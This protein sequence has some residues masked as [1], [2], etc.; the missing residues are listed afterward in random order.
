MRKVQGIVRAWGVRPGGLRP[1]TEKK[2]LADL[3]IGHYKP[4]SGALRG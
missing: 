4:K 3:K 2:R 1:C